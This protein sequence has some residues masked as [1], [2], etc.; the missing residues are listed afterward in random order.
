MENDSFKLNTECETSVF[1]PSLTLR[2]LK[3]SLENMQVRREKTKNMHN[4]ETFIY[5]CK[6]GSDKEE[7]LHQQR[8]YINRGELLKAYKKWAEENKYTG[9]RMEVTRK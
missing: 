8:G 6:I 2:K 7:V 1:V 4:E 5:G 9:I 3:Y